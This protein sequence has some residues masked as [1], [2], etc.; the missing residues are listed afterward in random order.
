[1]RWLISTLV[2]FPGALLA[3]TEN[4]SGVPLEPISSPYLFKLTGGL[5]LVVV[6]IFVLAWLVKKFNLNQQSHN[7]L[8][9]IVA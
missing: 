9:R 5:I 7:G 3:Q 6:V 4:Q 8:I 1:M 2:F